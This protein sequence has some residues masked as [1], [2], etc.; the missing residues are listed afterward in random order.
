MKN[1][2]IAA[3]LKRILWSP[4]AVI[5]TSELQSIIEDLEA[6]EQMTDTLKDALKRWFLNNSELSKHPILGDGKREFFE[7]LGKVE[8]LESRNSSALKELRKKVEEQLSIGE[9]IEATENRPL[10]IVGGNNALRQ[11][12]SEIDSLL[13]QEGGQK[14]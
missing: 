8:A 2:E 9:K 13:Q 12:L 11:V 5:F 7:L 6:K 3:R 14:G 10:A 4:A 1:A